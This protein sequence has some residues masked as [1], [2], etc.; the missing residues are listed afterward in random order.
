LLLSDLVY[1]QPFHKV[2]KS[3]MLKH[4]VNINVLETCC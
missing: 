4:L 3:C 2:I 1:I